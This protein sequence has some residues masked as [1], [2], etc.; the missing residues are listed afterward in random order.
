MGLLSKKIKVNDKVTISLKNKVKLDEV[1]IDGKI[2]AEAIKIKMPNV[3]GLTIEHAKLVLRKAG[4]NSYIFKGKEVILKEGSVYAT[5][6][7]AGELVK[8]D[9]E[10]ILYVNDHLTM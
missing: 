1:V 10:V 9:Q 2:L 8:L 3:V 7:K 4:I 6:P 5:S